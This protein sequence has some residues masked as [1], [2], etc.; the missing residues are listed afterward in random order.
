MNILIRKFIKNWLFIATFFMCATIFSAADA[1]ASGRS[2]VLLPMAIQTR[3]SGSPTVVYNRYYFNVQNLSSLVQTVTVSIA[4]GSIVTCADDTGAK[5]NYNSTSNILQT[6]TQVIPAGGH[7]SF[8][9]TLM[10]DINHKLDGTVLGYAIAGSLSGAAAPNSPN[11][12]SNLYF[13]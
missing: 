9:V 4:N 13:T 8:D 1:G 3:G 10:C 6:Q 11:V 7:V 12:Y 2:L 5:I